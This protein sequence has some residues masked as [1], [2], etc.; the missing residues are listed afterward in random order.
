MGLN[1]SLYGILTRS[2]GN[3]VS[4]EHHGYDSILTSAVCGALSGALSKLIVYPLDTLKRRFQAQVLN[5][6]FHLQHAEQLSTEEIAERY[7]LSLPQNRLGVK[8]DG[9]SDGVMRIFK[10]EGIRGFYKGVV[11]SIWKALIAT[12]INFSIYEVF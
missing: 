2:I 7:R 10:K 8:Y 9:I 1:F 6:T 11:P 3:S 5:T 4:H 12:S